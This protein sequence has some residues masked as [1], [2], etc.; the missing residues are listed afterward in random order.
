MRDSTKRPVRKGGSWP[1]TARQTGI[2]QSHPTT[3]SALTPDV[4]YNLAGGQ[5]ASFLG[6][7]VLTRGAGRVSNSALQ[8]SEAIRIPANPLI[9]HFCHRGMCAH[10][11]FVFCL[12]GM[13]CLVGV[14]IGVTASPVHQMWMLLKQRRSHFRM[15]RGK[16]PCTADQNS[17]VASLLPSHPKVSGG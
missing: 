9:T 17:H 14:C 10:Q 7:R 1:T 13:P 12:R 8:K 16:R 3:A 5:H 2:Q 11:L 4:R 15:T 6:W